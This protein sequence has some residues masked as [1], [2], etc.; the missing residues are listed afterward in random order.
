M[1]LLKKKVVFKTPWFDLE[2]KPVLVDGELHKYYSI[3]GGNCVI[4]I[5]EDDEN[6][7]LFVKQFRPIMEK[8][9]IELPRGMI[10]GDMSEATAKTE[11]LEETGYEANRWD[12]LGE[13]AVDSGRNNG[14]L[15]C[16]YATG[17]QRIGEPEKG[18]TVVRLQILEFRQILLQGGFTHSLCMSALFLAY[19]KGFL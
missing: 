18:S 4:I 17:L 11:L 14:F 1:D 8:F 3:N 15:H 10:E 2:E 5:A 12:F 7:I 6:N 9:V 16:Y 13:I 19:L